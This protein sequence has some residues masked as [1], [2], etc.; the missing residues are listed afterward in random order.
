MQGMLGRV[1]GVGH[2]PRQGPLSKT[3]HTKKVEF[4][5]RGMG[6]FSLCFIF[7]FRRVSL[8]RWSILTMRTRC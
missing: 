1:V 3:L 2:A 7:G 6:F 5:R 4:W 8:M